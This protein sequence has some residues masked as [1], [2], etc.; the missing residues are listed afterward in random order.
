MVAS[1]LILF[2]LMRRTPGI[3]KKLYFVTDMIDGIR[4]APILVASAASVANIVDEEGSL[5]LLNQRI[6]I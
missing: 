6:A 3:S 4:T 5:P 1:N 2:L